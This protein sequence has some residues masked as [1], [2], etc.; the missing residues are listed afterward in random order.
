MSITWYD[1]FGRAQCISVK[2]ESLRANVVGEPTYD[3]SGDTS[4]YVNDRAVAGYHFNYVFKG[5]KVP[6]PPTLVLFPWFCSA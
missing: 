1:T 3:A 5:P 4:A 6:E 2:S